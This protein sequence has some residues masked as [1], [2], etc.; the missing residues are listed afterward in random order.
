MLLYNKTVTIFNHATE[1]LMEDETW[2]PTVLH[3]VRLIE[4]K[5]LNVSKSGSADADSA[6]LHIKLEGL[7]KTFMEPVAWSQLDD[8]SE[9][10]TLCQEKDFFVVGDASYEEVTGDFFNHMKA[11]FDGVYQITSVDK[12]ELI[13]HLEVGGR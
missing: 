11:N 13:P 2:Y 9:A 4:T 10:F 1:D 5:G 8:K 7:K 3:N 12:F 6:K